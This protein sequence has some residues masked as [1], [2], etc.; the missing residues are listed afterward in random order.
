MW[1]NGIVMPPPTL[2]DDLRLLQRVE[3]LSIQQLVSEP[4][5]E[6]WGT[7]RLRAQSIN[8]VETSS[9]RMRR[10]NEKWLTYVLKD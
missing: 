5:V 2:D 10:G 3:N 1:A 7:A 8:S 6:V 4:G 9:N